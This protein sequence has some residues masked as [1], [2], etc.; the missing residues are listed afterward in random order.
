M[1]PSSTSSTTSAGSVPSVVVTA[2]ARLHLGF[3]D[4]D[5][6]LGR[7]FGGLGVAI[8]Q[9]RL[10]LEAWRDPAVRIEG[11]LDGRVEP[12]LHHILEYYAVDQGVAIRCRETIPAHVGLGSGTQLSLAVAT[13][14]AQLFG[15]DIDIAELAHVT[16]RGKRSGIGVAAFDRG[17]F[18]LDGGRK[19]ANGIPTVIFRHP[20]PEEWRFVVVV[21][22][23]G[24]GLHGAAEEEALR[25]LAT[26]PHEEIGAVCRLILMQ[27]LPSLIE[28][29]LERFGEALTTVQRTV[30]KW[31]APIQGGTFAAEIAKEVL[32][33]MLAQGAVGV[34]QSSWGPTLYGLVGGSERARHLT[35]RLRQALDERVKAGIFTAG[36]NNRGA[37]IEWVGAAGAPDT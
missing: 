24:E 11:D 30:G 32:E 20:F 29:D 1:P 12:L 27:L 13:A 35:E 10:V 28:E 15:L 3:I 4:P 6:S 37:T 16:G 31:F 25:R 19:T 33:L 5:G 9:P 22:D 14:V 21:P 7:R 36:A 17:G 23:L 34:G 18:I 2:P 8:D 26:P